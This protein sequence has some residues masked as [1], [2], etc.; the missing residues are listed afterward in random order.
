VASHFF[1]ALFSGLV[2]EKMRLFEPLIHIKAKFMI[3]ADT[4][5]IRTVKRPLS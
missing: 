4:A 3:L 2:F 1:M 5:L